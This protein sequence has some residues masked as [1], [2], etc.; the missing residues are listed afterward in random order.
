MYV[1]VSVIIDEL[2]AFLFC[3]FVFSCVDYGGA[4]SGVGKMNVSGTRKQGEIGCMRRW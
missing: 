1:S 2:V 3:F 4:R